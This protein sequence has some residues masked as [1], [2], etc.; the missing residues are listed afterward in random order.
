[1]AVRTVQVEWVGDFKTGQGTITPGSGE[2]TAGYCYGS[3]AGSGPGTNP[4]EMLGAAVAGCFTSTLALALSL[5]GYAPKR[6]ST[7]A[8]AYLEKVGDA[9]AI[10]RIEM[11]AQA[12]VPGIDESVL[13]QYADRVAKDCPVGKAVSGSEI[14]VVIHLV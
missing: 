7:D 6:I 1:M 9:Y 12:D 4:T 10:T 3:I 5:A 11:D 14:S 13:Q 8:K 2:F